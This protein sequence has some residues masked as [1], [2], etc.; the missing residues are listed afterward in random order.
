MCFSGE[1]NGVMKLALRWHGHQFR[2]GIEVAY[3]SLIE[4]NGRGSVMV[5]SIA[6]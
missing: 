5:D 6:E 2:A 4:C 1:K 3:K